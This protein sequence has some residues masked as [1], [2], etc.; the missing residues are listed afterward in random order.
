MTKNMG[1]TIKDVSHDKTNGSFNCMP[2]TRAPMMLVCNTC[3]P[4]LLYI[5]TKHSYLKSA[6]VQGNTYSLP[7]V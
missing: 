5:Y 3:S 2:S 7:P 4:F 6:L 1:E